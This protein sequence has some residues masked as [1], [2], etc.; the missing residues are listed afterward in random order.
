MRVQGLVQKIISDYINL[1][2]QRLKENMEQV[3][4]L[5]RYNAT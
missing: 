3:V 1:F 4:I 2:R 5:L